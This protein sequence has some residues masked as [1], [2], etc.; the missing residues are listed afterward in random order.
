MFKR[1]SLIF[2][3]IL[4]LQLFLYLPLGT[5]KEA[6]ARGRVPQSIVVNGDNVEYLT[7]RQEVV[8]EGNVEIIYEGTKLT[9]R[10]LTVNTKTKQGVAEG[11]VRLEDEKGIVEGERVTYDFQNKT[12]VILNAKF[13]ANPYFGSA[14]NIDRLSE[15]EFVARYGRITTCSFDRPH[16]N[17]LSKEMDILPGDKVLTRENVSYLGSV[18]FLYL[19]K[20]S[21][22]FGDPLMHV[23]VMPGK[24]KDWGPYVLSGWKYNLTDYISGRIYLDYRSKLGV[25]EGFGSNYHIPYFGKGDFKF[26]YSHEDPKRS[27]LSSKAERT[28]FQRYL[29]RLRH[30]WD[31]SEHT[32]FVAELYKI[33]DDRR[34]YNDINQN[35]LKDYFFREYE[36]DSQPL[37][38][39]L[40]HHNFEYSSINILAQKRVNRWF[41]QLDK[42]PQ[43]TYILPNIKLW[44]TPLY[45]ENSSVF[46]NFNK[47]GPMYP[48]TAEELKM[49]RLDIINKVSMPMK[50]AFLDFT[51]FLK[52]RQVIYDKGAFGKSLPVNTIFY[53]GADLST[54]FYRIYNIKA[55]SLGI[56]LNGLRHIITPTVGY[57]YNH[58]PTIS[59][60]KLKYID[61]VDLLTSSNAFTLGLSNKLQTKRKGADGIE[62]TI[63]FLDLNI[64]TKYS[65]GPN[66]VYGKYY[67]T[68]QNE[69]RSLMIKPGEPKKTGASF[70]DIFIKYKILP[71]SW[72]RIEGDA[73]Y[74]H[75][76]I[77]DDP[78][79]GSYNRFTQVNYDINFDFAKERSLGIGQRYERKGGNQVTASF[80]WRLNPKWRLFVYQRYNLK[81]Y[82]DASNAFIERGTLEQEFTVSRDLHCWEMDLTLNHKKNHGSGIYVVFRLKAFPEAEFGFDQSYNKP[83]SGAQ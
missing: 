50:V 36:K 81:S 33:G 3:A 46:A 57:S 69:T 21:H 26:Y 4:F 32:N 29:V 55:D 31:I 73:T 58:S 38:Y 43:I 35:I 76:G 75:S 30:K 66:H 65:L 60:T 27:T 83:K 39:A 64:S 22:V 14:R 48:V 78:D 10:K 53:A 40:F 25:A 41:D 9:C 20:L 23:R 34:K 79:F 16:Y 56:H 37:S 82:T 18:P 11:N 12:G 1:F 49:S 19:P 80:N 62:K 5:A 52:D 63:D 8:A 68:E 2:L 24:S 6:D 7:E 13:R 72:L 51:P 15:E 61:E 45:F 47:K 77:E 70:S 71:Y 44:D 17:I 59:A 67:Y 28:E 42:L 74:K 54:K